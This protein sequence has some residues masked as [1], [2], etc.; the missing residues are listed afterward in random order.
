MP[1]N[2]LDIVVS[3]APLSTQPSLIPSTTGVLYIGDPNRICKFCG[4]II[5][6]LNYY[7]IYFVNMTTEGNF[8]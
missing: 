4:G 7:M 8:F 6:L 5:G 2:Q 1:Y 3:D